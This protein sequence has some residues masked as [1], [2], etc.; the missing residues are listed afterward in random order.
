[1]SARYELIIF[2]WDGTLM[3]S[4]A[5]IAFCMNAAAKTVGLPALPDPQI[6]EIV[7]LALPEAIARL[8]PQLDETG[9]EH[10]RKAYAH[11]YVA[12]EQQQSQLFEG[13]KAMLHGLRNAGMH[14]SVATGKSR[15]GL[16]RVMSALEVSHLFSSS[17]CADE[18][19][20]KPNPHMVLE[21]LEYHQLSPQQAVV[22]GDTEFDMEMALSAGVDRIAVGWGAHEA[23]RLM[24]Y[25]P[26]LLAA[27]VG[28]LER[29]LLA[30]A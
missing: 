24:R 14:L 23:S 9:V 11:H 16:D 17:R 30:K 25:Q 10:M 4:L 27:S 26:E 20:P 13:V 15:V 28:E 1:M 18:T 6:H 8:Y 2:D 5:K 7:G 29:W 12:S 22:V 19:E 3:D 21:L